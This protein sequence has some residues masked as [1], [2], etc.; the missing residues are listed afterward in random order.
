VGFTAT[1]D[2]LIFS[3]RKGAK[4][5][6]YVVPLDGRLLKQIADAERRRDGGPAQPHDA[7]R[8]GSPRLVLPESSLTPREMQDRIRSGWSVDE[9]AAEAGVDLDW[10]G[11][12]A[13]P[14][15]AEVRQVVEQGRAAVYDK[16]RFGPSSMPLGASVRRNILD[17]GV[18][19][20]A[21]DL[22]D[23]WSAYQIDEE[24]WVL[25]FE[26]VSRG[27][28]QEAEWVYDVDGEELTSRNR[29]GSQLGH[30]A[31]GRPRR[32]AATAVPAMPK[33]SANVVRA[34][35]AARAA[36]AS[37]APVARTTTRKSAA[38]KTT[39][40]KSTART[41]AA[42]R[43]KASRP[44]KKPTKERALA[45]VVE[46]IPA[47]A[48]SRLIRPM[49]MPA[50][51]RARPVA[52]TLRP[53]DWAPDV[54]G[55]PVWTPPAPEPRSAP[56]EHEIEPDPHLPE[57]GGPAESVAG[58]L[59][60]PP[61]LPVSPE[62]REAVATPIGDDDFEPPQPGAAEI[63]DEHGIARIDSR[64]MSHYVSTPPP[65]RAVFRGD[66]TRAQ[67]QAGAPGPRRPRRTEPLRGR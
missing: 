34:A 25:R 24:V 48:P 21:E 35:K 53:E 57:P 4:S 12:F 42:P 41:P 60:P 49:V 1:F 55:R 2:G 8:S 52:R 11:R 37:P 6:N 43:K 13:A 9:V 30:V 63:D 28:S 27:R 61:P 20:T 19:L 26:Y 66:V 54:P 40:R 32:P 39:A 56:P 23:C 3:T 62:I 15:L 51:V 31:R 46:T 47:S 33:P 16:P 65:P 36:G 5:G 29:L 22:D 67:S 18:Q 14:V 7:P 58:P 44:A 17:R 50:P 64:R 10:V 59:P 45:V 38:R